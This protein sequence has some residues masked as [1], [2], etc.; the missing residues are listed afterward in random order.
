MHLKSQFFAQSRSKILNLFISIIHIFYS[1]VF[2]FEVLLCI[3]KKKPKKFSEIR[4]Y[5]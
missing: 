5:F 2:V 3:Y 4:N 1:F